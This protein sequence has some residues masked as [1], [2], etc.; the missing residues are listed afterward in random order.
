MTHNDRWREPIPKPSMRVKEPKPLRSRPKLL[1]DKV[2]HD[3][4]S[5]AG[6]RCERCSASGRLEVHHV[7]NRSQGG[8]NDG[9]P[10]LAALCP[11]CHRFL[12]DH[13]AQA[14]A[15]GW[16]IGRYKE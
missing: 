14:R 12:T 5:A 10:P 16:S 7:L 8:R 3:V 4:L 15:D 13:P 9:S 1:P 6:W 11:P 2:R